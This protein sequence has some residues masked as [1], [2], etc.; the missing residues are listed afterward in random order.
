MSSDKSARSLTYRPDVDGL[1]AVAVV[2]VILN[3]LDHRLLPGGY[4]G[5]DIFFVIS[6]FVI[7]TSL[8]QHPDERLGQLLGGFFARRFR[9]LVP[10]LALCVAVS[11]LAVWTIAPNPSESLNIGLAALA[12]VSNIA[13]LWNAQ[14]YF[15]TSAALNFFTQTW[16]LGVEEQFYL[17]FPFLVWGTG[18]TRLGRG[19]KRLFVV[20]LILSAL[21]VVALLRLPGWDGGAAYFLVVS[22]FW[23]L[24]CGVMAALL[25]VRRRRMPAWVALAVMIGAMAAPLPPS[26]VVGF[27]VVPPAV[28][29]IQGDASKPLAW[30]VFVGLGR[31]S[32]S[33]YL[34]HWPVIGGC[35]LAFG[36][37]H[38]DIPV[39]LAPMLLLGAASYYLVERPA[40]TRLAGLPRRW[41]FAVA[42]G[43][44]ALTGGLLA[45][46]NN[47]TN[48]RPLMGRVF[49]D[50]P[51]WWP[52]LP[53]T[54]VDHMKECVIDGQFRFAGPTTFDRCTLA[55]YAG[56]ANRVWA[57]GD[58][59]AGALD[60]ML[61][62]LYRQTGLGIHLIET[63][64]K[65]FPA[66][67]GLDFPDRNAFF[68]TTL[69]RIEPGDIVLLARLFI[70]RDGPLRAQPDIGPWISEVEALAARVRPLGAQVVVAGPPPIFHFDTIY[71]CAR[72]PDGTTPCDVDRATLA[73][74][75]DPVMALLDAAARRQPNLHVFDDFTPLCPP[76]RRTCSPVK[77]D[78]PQFR[79]E[80]HLNGA[81]AASLAPAFEAFLSRAGLFHPKP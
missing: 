69:T 12:G 51:A 53:V 13:L 8:R 65:P 52:P 40:R 16:S 18:L 63:P 28:I 57:M 7:T 2:A 71:R 37:F 22:R 47:W 54:L 19:P 74:A 10:A 75:I 58:S 25:P 32:Y 73:A 49:A 43:S 31:M 38:L 45:G 33:L 14:D 48:P 81:G 4:L 67:P 72:R 24:G 55:P 26:V 59:H 3:H 42:F 66:P 78:I 27:L 9:R 11:G 30:P 34:W 20:C 68:A 6:G 62:A 35:L 64:G 1:R 70:R 17:L 80:D 44:L 15:A 61:V 29:V 50:V 79:D 5:V 39:R 76:E 36:R 60:G 23:E 56:V 46:L 21:S 41:S 77:D